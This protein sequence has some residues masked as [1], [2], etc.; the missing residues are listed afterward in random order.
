MS[1]L[2]KGERELLERLKF[3]QGT[4][5]LSL[6]DSREANAAITKCSTHKPM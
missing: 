4:N 1:K 6:I 3:N 2:E 5:L